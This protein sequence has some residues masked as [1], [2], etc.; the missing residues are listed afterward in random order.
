MWEET[1]SAT[2]PRSIG[3]HRAQ[4]TIA[5]ARVPHVAQVSQARLLQGARAAEIDVAL[6]IDSTT[7]A[8]LK[9]AGAG[10]ALRNAVHA[11][12]PAGATAMLGG[13][14]AVYADV[15]SSINKDLRLISRSPRSSSC[16]S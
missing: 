12:T 9:L 3:A 1:V 6:N 13:T 2:S 16:S 11:T 15:S 8:A 14:A 10:G 5:P 4:A 7:G